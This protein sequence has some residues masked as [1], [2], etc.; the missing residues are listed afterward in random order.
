MKYKIKDEI[1]WKVVDEE[2]VIVD[3]E[4]DNYSYLNSTGTKVWML[5]DKGYTMEQI[6]KD[7]YKEYNAS[8]KKIKIDVQRIIKR[9]VKI[10]LLE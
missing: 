9:L 8:K 1:L 7:L 6:L 2:A 4:K 5:I 10:G 3:M